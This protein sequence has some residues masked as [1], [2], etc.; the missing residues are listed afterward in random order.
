MAIEVMGDQKKIYG[1]GGEGGGGRAQIDINQSLDWQ[2]TGILRPAKSQPEWKLDSVLIAKVYILGWNDNANRQGY[3]CFQE[4]P[5]LHLF[6]SI[7]RRGR[8]RW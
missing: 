7:T 8:P 5:W 6:S 2:S 3:P 1:K 4:Q